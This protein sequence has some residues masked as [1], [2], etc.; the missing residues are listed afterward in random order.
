MRILLTND[1]GIDCDGIRFLAQAITKYTGHEVYIVAPDG[2]RSGVSH[3]ITLRGPIRLIR[4]SDR[5]W[6]CSGTPADCALV[7]AL[8]GLPFIPELVV[9]GMNVGPNI[10]TD[11]VYSGTAAAAR[12]AALHGIP[13]IAFSLAAHEGP[14]AWESASRFAAEKLEELIALWVPDVF[15][16]VNIPNAQDGPR[17][18][19]CTFPSRRRYNDSLAVFKAPDGNEYCFIN[20]G[21]IDT[22]SE[23]GSDQDAILRGY[24]SASPVFIH[25]VVR[26]DTCADFPD[27]AAASARPRK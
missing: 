15:I 2:N 14:W 24:A 12:Q 23:A 4:H 16:N 19:E 22:E 5:E 8:G 11:L 7:A 6:A 25:P 10:G 26:R 3:S 21:G 1:D 27:H 20:G 18:L 17:G 9:S 13:A